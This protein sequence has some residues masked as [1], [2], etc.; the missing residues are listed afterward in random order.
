MCHYD[1][2]LL[3][4]STTAANTYCGCF[5]PR[6][7][8]GRNGSRVLGIYGDNFGDVPSFPGPIIVQLSRTN[9][10]GVVLKIQDDAP[11]APRIKRLRGEGQPRAVES[12]YSGQVGGV[13]S[14]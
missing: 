12:S 2:Q 10:T 11:M 5:I 3:P 4:V 8:D 7:C 9:L 14:I 6:I 13:E 1:G